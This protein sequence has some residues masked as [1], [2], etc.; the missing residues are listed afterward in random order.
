M[1]SCASAGRGGYMQPWS[2]VWLQHCQAHCLS[3]KISVEDPDPH[4]QPS[5]CI[6]VH[7]IYWNEKTLLKWTGS[8]DN[9]LYLRFWEIKSVLSA[10][11]SLV[12][13]FFY[14][15]VPEIF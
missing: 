3:L 2:A 10:G 15:V 8:P 7:R 6:R 12:F 13:T 1:M 9:G 4:P 11:S 14:L 5:P